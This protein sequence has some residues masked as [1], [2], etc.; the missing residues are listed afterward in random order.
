VLH[1]L[2]TLLGGVPTT[3]FIA[4]CSFVMG[5][6]LGIPLAGAAR[7]RIKPLA[8]FTR[9]LIDLIRAIPPIVWLF[10]LFYGIATAV[11]ALSAFPAAIIGLG[12]VSAAYMAEVYRGGLLAVKRGQWQA[13]EALGLSRTQTMLRVVG[14]QAFRVVLPGSAAWA[15]ALLK[16]T[17]AVSIIGIQD[18]AFR[19]LSENQRTLDGLGVFA[20]AALIYIA[21]SVPFAVLARTADA[22]IR[23]QVVR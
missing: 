9:F 2:W 22:R 12:V 4:L 23:R 14:P 3:L 1:Y 19:A 17:A 15:I 10:L 20:V 21:I 13:A 6:V 11:Y 7:S 16:E 8:F 5:A 18:I